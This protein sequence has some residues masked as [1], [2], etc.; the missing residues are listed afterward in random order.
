MTH[1][2]PLGTTWTLCTSAD[3]GGALA[4]VALH[5]DVDGA[6]RVMGIVGVRPGRVVLRD[7]AGID[8]GLVVR[9]SEDHAYLMPHAGPAVVRGLGAFLSARGIGHAETLQ[10]LS[11]YPEARSEIEARALLALARAPSSLAVEL[12][13]VQHELWA[14]G[15]GHDPV[16]DRV[17]RRLLE[18]PLVVAVGATNIGKSSLL[19]SLAKRNV[20]IVADEPGTTRDHVG[21]MLDLGGLVVRW[22][23]SP[24]VRETDDAEEVRAREV[25]L[26]LA[27]RADM[28]VA[29]GDAVHPPVLIPGAREADTLTLALRTDLGEPTWKH[30]ARVSV[31]KNEG[32]EEFIGGLRERL[33]P[34]WFLASRQAWR[35]WDE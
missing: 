6:L 23:D 15:A 30:D 28:V 19:N 8:T 34:A 13:L 9:W 33:V 10:P 25:A 7:F 12:L 11:M 26:A 29:C 20:A 17:L 24:G 32:L 16:R 22:V 21:V 2:A 5:G 3:A 1:G 27:S 4:V 18:P 35:F 31:V 14:E